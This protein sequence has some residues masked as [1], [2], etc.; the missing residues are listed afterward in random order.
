M[1]V[2]ESPGPCA[3]PRPGMR[4]RLFSIEEALVIAGMLRLTT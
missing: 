4:S 1:N 3:L 2:T